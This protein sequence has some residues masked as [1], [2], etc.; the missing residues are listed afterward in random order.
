MLVVSK[1]LTNDSVVIVSKGLIGRILCRCTKLSENSI[2]THT[3]THEVIVCLIEL[4]SQTTSRQSDD[5]GGHLSMEVNGSE[6]R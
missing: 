6:W 2:T 1:S 4:Y 5:T 3:G